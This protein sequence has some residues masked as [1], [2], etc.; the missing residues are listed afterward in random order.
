MQTLGRTDDGVDIET[1]PDGA[2]VYSITP[3]VVT[4]VASDPSG[5]GP[6][7]PVIEASRG[8]LAGTDIYYGHVARA[9]VVPG[10]HVA[11]GQPIAVM[12]H[13]GDA[14][15]LGHGHI[16]IGFSTAGGD[17]LNHHG[18]TAWTPTGEVMRSFL[19]TL[20]DAFRAQARDA[21]ATA[22]RARPAHARAR[23]SGVA[24]RRRPGLAL[25]L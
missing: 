19:V 15:S 18:A 21:H 2:L 23:H 10:Q 5:F 11:A 17:P 12:G 14:V 8:A 24:P 22:A 6:N 13:T 4:A 20:T 7:Y 25:G 1:A 16:E 9:F 3:G